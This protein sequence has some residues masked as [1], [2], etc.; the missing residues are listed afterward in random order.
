MF[1][2]ILR[3]LI[4]VELLIVVISLLLFFNFRIKG[5]EFFMIYYLVFRVCERVLGLIILV[6]IVRFHGNEYYV[7]INLFKFK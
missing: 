7:S 5:I 1:K 3:V 2:Y 6:L 4:I